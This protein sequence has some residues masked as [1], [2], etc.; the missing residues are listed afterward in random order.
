MAIWSLLRLFVYLLVCLLA[1]RLFVTAFFTLI[2]LAVHLT[3]VA[4]SAS[5]TPSLVAVPPNL[6]GSQISSGA[7]WVYYK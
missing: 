7:F 1:H 3:A 5:L 4:S 2:G 6:N